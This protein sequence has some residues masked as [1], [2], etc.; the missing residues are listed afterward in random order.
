MFHDCSHEIL[1]PTLLGGALRRPAGGDRAPERSQADNGGCSSEEIHRW[2]ISEKI[3]MV[4][5]WFYISFMALFTGTKF[6]SAQSQFGI[7]GPKHVW[8]MSLKNWSYGDLEAT[9]DSQE[10]SKQTAGALGV[11]GRNVHPVRQLIRDRLIKECGPQ[12]VERRGFFAWKVAKKH[13]IIVHYLFEKQC[14]SCH[15]TESTFLF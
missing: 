9:N 13:A 11:N 4:F 5:T 7:E 10:I 3:P 2:L 15:C 14:T 12:Q 8:M 6:Q 1:E